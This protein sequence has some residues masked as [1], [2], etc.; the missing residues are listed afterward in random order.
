MLAAFA[1]GYAIGAVVLNPKDAG[2]LW[3][4]TSLSTISLVDGPSISGRVLRSGERGV[5]VFDALD[6]SVQFK[7]WEEI[8][9]I[10]LTGR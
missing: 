3:H 2:P 5:L 1:E 8:R 9:G 4:K 7:R 10:D 6:G